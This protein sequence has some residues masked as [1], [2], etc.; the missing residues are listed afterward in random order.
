MSIP[1]FLKQK[2]GVFK[3]FSAA[4]LQQLVDGSRVGSFEAREAIVHQGAEATHF[5]VVLSGTVSVSVPGDG[6]VRQSLG[7]LNAGETFGE[8]AL[9]TGEAVLADFIAES[10][11]EVMLI[12]VSLFQSSIV[13]EPHAVQHI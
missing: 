10:R 4:R 2:V 9:M 12:P 13:A 5:G 7:R 1:E 6:G 8:M 3:E 11:C